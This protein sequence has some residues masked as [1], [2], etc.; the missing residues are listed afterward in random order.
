MIKRDS[1]CTCACES[2]TYRGFVLQVLLVRKEERGVLPF[3][4]AVVVLQQLPQQ[5]AAVSWILMKVVVLLLPLPL[6]EYVDLR[7]FRLHQKSCTMRMRRQQ[8]QHSQ[9]QPSK[10]MTKLRSLTPLSSYVLLITN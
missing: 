7:Q 3:P 9:P 8:L 1:E 10:G 2:A 6:L 5:N 4:P